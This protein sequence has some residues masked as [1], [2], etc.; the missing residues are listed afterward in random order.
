MAISVMQLPSI[1]ERLSVD[2]VVRFVVLRYAEYVSFV[3]MAMP[4]EAPD[5]VAI[6]DQDGEHASSF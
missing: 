1:V 3:A 6:L 2:N 5:V 4:F